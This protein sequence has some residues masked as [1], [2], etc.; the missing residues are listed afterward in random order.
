MIL[1]GVAVEGKWAQEEAWL[2][3]TVT[4]R[5][6]VPRAEIWAVFIV[7]MVWDG[8]YDLA[9]VTDASYT[10]KGMGRFMDRLPRRK[11]TR[12]QTDTYGPSSTLSWTRRQAPAYSPS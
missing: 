2:A 3:S 1:R 5:E 8:A 7:L 6:T 10:G 4:G 11:N 12:G 9:I